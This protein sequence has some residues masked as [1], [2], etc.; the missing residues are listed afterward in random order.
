[1][2]QTNFLAHQAAQFAHSLWASVDDPNIKTYF[3]GD[4][5]NKGS[6]TA[7]VKAIDLSKLDLLDNKLGA[8]HMTVLKDALKERVN[9]ATP[10]PGTSTSSYLKSD[11][12]LGGQ[13]IT[14]LED[15]LKEKGRMESSGNG[16]SSYSYKNIDNLAKLIKLIAGINEGNGRS[17]FAS[18]I[19]ELVLNTRNIAVYLSSG[20]ERNFR[21]QPTSYNFFRWRG[22]LYINNYLGVC[23]I[24]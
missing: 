4:S 21:N 5:V 24:C 2:I 12:N 17:E 13:H 6:G 9:P 7:G 15:A 3:Q 22:S 14:A 18:I 16:T 23:I 1:M 11:N 20:A 10:G 8:Q 19:S